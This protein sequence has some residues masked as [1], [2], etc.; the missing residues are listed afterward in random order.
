MPAR[1]VINLEE[2][3]GITATSDEF[4]VN[5]NREVAAVLRLTAGTPTTG[6]RLQITLDDAERIAAGT[7][8][9][10]NSPLGSRTSTD[11]LD[12]A[13]RLADA[14]SAE[15]RALADYEVAKIDLAVATGT[16]LGAS[17]VGWEAQGE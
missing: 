6:A 16:V 4:I 13:T 8:T 9:W 10:V 14:Q 15:I 3:T 2:Q 5:P 1:T 17:A 7:A 12:A 11:V